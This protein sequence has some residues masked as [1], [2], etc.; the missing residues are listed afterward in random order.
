MDQ[1]HC[2]QSQWQD[3][4]G[5]PMD[6]YRREAEE[7][8]MQ[9]GLQSQDLEAGTGA[10]HSDPYP[11]APTMEVPRTQTADPTTSAIKNPDTGAS[12]EPVVTELPIRQ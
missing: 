6:D 12:T 5:L 7:R 2:F 11:E 8:R 3:D 10:G 1:C 9:R 4:V